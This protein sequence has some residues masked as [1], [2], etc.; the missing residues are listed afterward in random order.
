MC[1]LCENLPRSQTY[2]RART[3]NMH[4]SLVQCRI[5]WHSRA[6]ACKQHTHMHIYSLM[7]P[8]TLFFLTLVSHHVYA[9]ISWGSTPLPPPILPMNLKGALTLLD[10]NPEVFCLLLFFWC[11]CGL[12]FFFCFL[13]LLLCCILL[14]CKECFKKYYFHC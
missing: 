4:A 9:Q 11:S 8:R 10:L 2:I 1:L 12:F 14:V 13:F 3:L 6:H 5:H 7:R